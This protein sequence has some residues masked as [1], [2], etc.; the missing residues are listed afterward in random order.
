M[1]FQAEMGEIVFDGPVGFKIAG[2]FFGIAVFIQVAVRFSVF[3]A[4]LGELIV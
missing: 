3:I 2:E 4:P 1:L